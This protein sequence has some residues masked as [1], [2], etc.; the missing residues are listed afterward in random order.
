LSVFSINLVKFFFSF[1]IIKEKDEFKVE[2]IN[3]SKSLAGFIFNSTKAEKEISGI[4][5]GKDTIEF[6]NTSKVFAKIDKFLNLG[7]PDRLEIDDLNEEE[8]KEFLKVLADL[9]KRG[10]VGYEVLEVNGRPEKHYIVN[11]IGNE[12]LYGTKLYKRDGYYKD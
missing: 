10:I 12:R 9:L 2:P 1:P 11:Q 4:E 7:R 6:S 5:S 3:N 8:Q